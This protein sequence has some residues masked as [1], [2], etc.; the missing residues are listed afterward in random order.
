MP[1]NASPSGHNPD[2]LAEEALSISDSELGEILRQSFERNPRVRTSPEQLIHELPITPHLPGIADALEKHGRLIITG[3]PGIG[4]TTQVP[5]FFARLGYRV[6]HTLP[7]R[8]AVTSLQAEV[9]RQFGGKNGEVV[10]FK[11]RRG[12]ALGQDFKIMFCTDGL[13]FERILREKLFSSHDQINSRDLFIIDEFHIANLNI[14]HTLAL[15]RKFLAL[16]SAPKLIVMSATIDPH[17]VARFL[18]L[19]DDSGNPQDAPVFHIEGR[20]FPITDLEAGDSLVS[21]TLE[22]IERGRGHIIVFFPGAGEIQKMQRELD[23]Y[24]HGALIRPLYAKLSPGAQNLV[25]Q[26]TPKVKVVLATNVAETSLTIR[27]VTTVING[28]LERVLQVE[29][30]EEMLVQ[31]VNSQS[32]LR[33]RRGRCGRDSEGFFINHGQPENLLP[34]G[35]WDTQLLPLHK[36]TLKL[37]VADEDPMSLSLLH[38]PGV[39]KRQE[40]IRWLQ[41]H[42]FLSED[43]APTTL[44]RFA[45]SLPVEPREAKMI[46]FGMAHRDSD[47]DLFSS[48]IDIATILSVRDFRQRGA[49]SLYNLIDSSLHTTIQRSEGLGNLCALEAIYSRSPLSS[50]SQ[51]FRRFGIREAAADEVLQLR[52]EIAEQLNF[53]ISPM[54]SRKLWTLSPDLLHEASALSWSDHIYQ[55]AGRDAGGTA[56]YVNSRDPEAPYRRISRY[57]H[58]GEPLLVTGKPFSIGLT[59]NIKAED[60]ILRLITQACSIPAAWFTSN[61]ELREFEQ[62]AGKCRAAELREQK[63]QMRSVQTPRKGHSPGKHRKRGNG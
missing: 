30:D 61:P 33:Q 3:E 48:I 57:A 41:R 17:G 51:L 27:G 19:P 18:S 32:T 35:Y 49:D 9:E 28:G 55:F 40:S 60:D 16:G 24:P 46:M 20:Q 6:F 1:N 8:L 7:T 29:G 4:K 39:E 13:C 42:G 10:G 45:A 38:D 11:H 63:K 26:E 5:Q 59:P 62:A 56:L 47:P 36:H 54:G 50:R 23:G 31:R 25:N 22:H 53:P 15:Y 43:H 2:R 34:A 14:E 44:G 21:D 12:E 52:E 58:I 37:I